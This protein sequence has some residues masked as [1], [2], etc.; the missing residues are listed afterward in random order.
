MPEDIHQRVLQAFQ[1]EH[2]EH[3]AGLRSFLERWPDLSP[4]AVNEMFRLA[5]SMKVGA[6]V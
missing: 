6:G 5:H 1:E 2:R 3:V 4:D